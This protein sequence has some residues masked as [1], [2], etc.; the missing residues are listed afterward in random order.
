MDG[1][2][3]IVAIVPI[4]PNLTMYISQL[5]EYCIKIAKHKK[6]YAMHLRQWLLK[7]KLTM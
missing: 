3:I 6:V 2:Y 5:L 4:E 1:S 7:V